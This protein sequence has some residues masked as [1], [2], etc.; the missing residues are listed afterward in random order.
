MR[1]LLF[2]QDEKSA[3]VLMPLVQGLDIDVMHE[4]EVFSAMRTLM[5]ERF[6][7]LIIDYEDE[8]TGRILLKNARGSAR[9]KAASAVAVVDP[10]SGANALRL[11]ADF[12]VRKPIN[13]G[14]AEGVLRLVRSSVLRRKVS[15]A[16]SAITETAA[17]GTRLPREA[18]ASPQEPTTAMSDELV[19]MNSHLT[20]FVRSF[21]EGRRALSPE[22]V[23]AEGENTKIA[24]DA[25][26]AESEQTVDGQDRRLQQ[27]NESLVVGEVRI[28][29]ASPPAHAASLEGADPVETTLSTNV[30]PEQSNISA[31]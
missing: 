25:M 5:A 15:S 24:L 3:R 7:F 19:T 6:D 4:T 28:Q 8:H 20:E 1:C 10:E 2:C 16:D 9:N 17:E 30:S 29:W 11:G 31:R 13:L 18:T 22:P 21:A 27:T 14:Q 26:I 12:L 23:E